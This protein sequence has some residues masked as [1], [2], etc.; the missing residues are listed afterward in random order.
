MNVYRCYYRQR[1]EERKM[2]LSGAILTQFLPAISC[3]KGERVAILTQFLASLFSTC[4]VS[5]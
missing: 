1:E 3:K 4:V 2:N 5:I